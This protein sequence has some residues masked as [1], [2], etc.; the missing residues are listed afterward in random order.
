MARESE[1]LQIEV[2][3]KFAKTKPTMN[4]FLGKVLVDLSF[5]L[6]KIRLTKG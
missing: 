4:R 2:K 5:I 3:D 6:D 1:Q